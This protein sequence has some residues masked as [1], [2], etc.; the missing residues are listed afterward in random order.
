MDIRSFCTGL[1]VGAILRRVPKAIPGKQSRN[2]SHLLTTPSG[3]AEFL[4]RVGNYHSARSDLNLGIRL[5]AGSFGE[6]FEG[7]YANRRSR[8]CAAGLLLRS[9]QSAVSKDVT[10]AAA[11]WRGAIVAVKILRHHKAGTESNDA[12]SFE[13]MIAIA[14]VHPNVV[15]S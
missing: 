10:F 14:T 12:V 3:E 9:T 8:S 11:T 6:V 4:T 5:G 13:A 2:R 1:L 7:A 15:S